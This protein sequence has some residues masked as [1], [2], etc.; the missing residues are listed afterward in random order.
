MNF[1]LTDD[2][3]TKVLSFKGYSVVCS[4]SLDNYRAFIFGNSPK[5]IEF[6]KLIYYFTNSMNYF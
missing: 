2:R 1:F 4:A 3:G 5:F 6:L